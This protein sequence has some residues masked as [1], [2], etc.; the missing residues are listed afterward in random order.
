M[1]VKHGDRSKSSCCEEPIL[2]DLA[3]RTFFGSSNGF[4]QLASAWLAYHNIAPRK[5]IILYTFDIP[6]V[7]D[8]DYVLQHDQLLNNSWRVVKWKLSAG[9]KTPSA[10]ILHTRNATANRITKMSNAVSPNRRNLS[11]D[12]EITSEFL[13]EH[14]GRKNV[15]PL[16]RHPVADPGLRSQ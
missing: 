6:Q 2:S 16:S 4:V 12:I 7:G 11:N 13:S 15:P 3:H 14:S 1:A 5:H 10:C 9:R 8:Y